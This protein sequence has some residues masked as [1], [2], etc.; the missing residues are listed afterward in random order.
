MSDSVMKL[1]LDNAEIEVEQS[2]GVIIQN[3]ESKK[4]D[5]ISDLRAE[6]KA[7]ADMKEY[8]FD[9]KK[10]TDMD[11]L[12][13]DACDMAKKYHKLQEEKGD[14][15]QKQDSLEQELSQ[16]KE[17]QEKTLLVTSGLI[18]AQKADSLSLE[19]CKKLILT[20]N[21]FDLATV[22]KQDSAF[23]DGAI[24][25]IKIT[26]KGNNKRNQSDSFDTQ[27]NQFNRMYNSSVKQDEFEDSWANFQVA[28]VDNELQEFYNSRRRG[29]G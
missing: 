12:V 29:N 9:G 13:R 24:A 5:E 22:E 6:I 17:T 11:D 8:N 26:N 19:D 1:K 15:K 27:V 25:T 18:N 10:Y 20:E 7:K 2:L 21:G 28:N 16:L 4:N 14:M 23:I 3:W